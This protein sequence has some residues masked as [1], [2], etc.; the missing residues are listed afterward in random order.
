MFSKFVEFVRLRF[1]TTIV[2]LF[3]F[4]KSTILVYELSTLLEVSN[5]I[6]CEDQLLSVNSK[7]S[8]EYMSEKL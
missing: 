5:R 7:I 8:M 4:K 6:F 2:K 3:I 1:R